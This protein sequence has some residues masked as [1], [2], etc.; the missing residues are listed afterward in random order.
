M[1]KPMAG[2]DWAMLLGLALVFGSAFFFVKLALAS[3]GPLTVALLRVSLGA[4]ILA[5]VAAIRGRAWP[6]GRS[7]WLSLLVMGALNNAIPFGLI[8]WGQTHIESGLAAIFNATTPIFTVIAAHAAGQERLTPRRLAGIAL[9]F[10][11]VAVLIGPESLSH[12]DPANLAELA[13]LLAA[14]SYAGAGIWGRR[15]RELPI[16]VAAGGML[17]GAALLL[18]P[19]ALILEQPW[20]V[21]PSTASLGAI[22]AL[23]AL[24]TAVAYLLYFRLL[25]RVGPTNL[26]LVTF[27]LP[28]VALALG[29]VFLQERIEPRDLAG[30]LLILGGL[31][32]IDGRLLAVLRATSPRVAATSGSPPDSRRS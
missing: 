14:I 15:L 29:T 26:L 23:G 25:R 24:S 4:A 3:Y 6:R 5:T 19:A 16:D 22:A 9:G 12:L 32:A 1:S 11:G 21:M 18:L 8:S 30:L 20:R 27:L 10:L 13:V 17:T 28:I 7:V 2:Q 31:A